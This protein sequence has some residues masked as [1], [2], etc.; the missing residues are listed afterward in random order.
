MSDETAQI[1][2]LGVQ[3]QQLGKDIGRLEKA[4]EEHIDSHTSNK[5]WFISMVCMFLTAIGGLYPLIY[6]A[7]RR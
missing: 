3:I 2:V 5:R 1:A 4:L 7:I 6:L